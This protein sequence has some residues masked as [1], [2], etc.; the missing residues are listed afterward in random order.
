MECLC[1]NSVVVHGY[2]VKS[3]NQILVESNAVSLGCST[4]RLEGSLCLNIQ[5]H[6]VQ[7]ILNMKRLRSFEVSGTTHPTPKRH[8]PEGWIF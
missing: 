4:L 8:V 1:L 3:E 7:D 6:A 5:I 2:D